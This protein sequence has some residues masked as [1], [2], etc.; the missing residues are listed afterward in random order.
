MIPE[1]LMPD[2]VVVVRP[3]RVTSGYGDPGLDYG[4][5]AERVTINARLEQTGG[6]EVTGGGRDAQVAD[7]Q[8]LST[9]FDITGS[10]RIEQGADRVFEVIGPPQVVSGPRGPSHLLANL[11]AVSG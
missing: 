2:I 5:G 3:A 10:D 9:D 11:R 4:A 1:R 8:L 6:R 7:W